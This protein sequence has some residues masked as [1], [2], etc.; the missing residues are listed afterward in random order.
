MSRDGGATWSALRGLEGRS[1][2]VFGFALTLMAAGTDRGVYTSANGTSWTQ[3]G[4]LN[5]SVS[6]EPASTNP[7][8]ACNRIYPRF[9]TLRL[10]TGE[11]LVQDVMKCHLKPVDLADYPAGAF[12]NPA[13]LARL[14]AIFPSDYRA[15]NRWCTA[16]TLTPAG[17]EIIRRDDS[18]SVMPAADVRLHPGRLHH[19]AFRPLLRRERRRRFW[20]RRP[21]E[22]RHLWP[23]FHLAATARAF[24][25]GACGFER[26]K[27]GALR[28]D[29]P[30]L[31]ACRDDLGL[32]RHGRHPSWTSGD[33][34]SVRQRRPHGAAC[35]HFAGRGADS[36]GPA[37][38]H[39]IG[40][41]R[42]RCD[43]DCDR[44]PPTR[45]PQ[46]AG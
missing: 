4:L 8:D 5:V 33:A 24:D 11:P 44:R 20:R 36:L 27:A 17:E 26:R 32:P 22:D 12:S 43:P 2:R 40:P 37:A 39:R 25:H 15:D 28:G 9:S 6:A 16:I 3:S 35:R 13:N 7:A 42:P 19:D 14:N 10:E 41:R 34:L 30:P 18:L 29:L 21:V 45:P 31:N 23:G 38:I 1:V 46:V